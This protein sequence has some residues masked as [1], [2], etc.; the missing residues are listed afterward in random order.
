MTKLHTQPYSQYGV[1]AAELL[2]VMIRDARLTRG[3]TVNEIATRA[4]LSRGLVR[5]IEAGHTSC[6]VGAMFELASLVGVPLFEAEP[7]KLGQQLNMA[8]DRLKLL[9]KRYRKHKQKVKDDF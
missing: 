4:G 9:P 1:D 6:S 5:R 3:F 2:G 8:R 7:A